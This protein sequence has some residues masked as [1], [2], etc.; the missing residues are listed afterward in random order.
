MAK[1][2]PTARAARKGSGLRP[3]RLTGTWT[4]SYVCPQGSTGLRLALKATAGGGLTA[5]FSFYP[6][7][8]NVS[9]P[10]GSF[11]LTGSYTAKGFE[12]TPD[13]WI[14]KPQ[15]YSMVGLTGAASKSD[16]VLSGS[17]VSPG[18]TT[19]SVSR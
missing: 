17:I 13:H 9:V 18:C 19:F 14:S 12:L 4:G 11:A 15:N 6:T 16:T 8:S 10:S 7:G 5:T 3:A 2:S 1:A